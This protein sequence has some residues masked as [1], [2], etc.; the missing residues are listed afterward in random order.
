MATQSRISTLTATVLGLVPMLLVL[1]SAA[2]GGPRVLASN[3]GQRPWS[4]SVAI[5]QPKVDDAPSSPMT[6]A[7]GPACVLYPIA[8]NQGT[9]AGI[10]A[11]TML[12]DIFNGTQPGNFGC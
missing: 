11:G 12:A 9:V 4:G 7:T 10:A 6:T 2:A 5:P 3:P 8:L 1:A